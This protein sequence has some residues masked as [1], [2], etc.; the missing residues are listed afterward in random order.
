ML[1]L[2]GLIIAVALEETGLHTRISLYVM[3]I[4]GAKP[5]MLASSV[6][7]FGFLFLFCS[8]LGEFFS[9]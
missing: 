6:Y 9:Q 3:L 8:M 5:I 4:V 7:L 1:F 2:G